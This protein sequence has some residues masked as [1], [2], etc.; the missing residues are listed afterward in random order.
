M[1]NWCYQKVTIA[2]PIDSRRN[3]AAAS[4][5]DVAAA[6]DQFENTQQYSFTK[7]VPLDA[8]AILKLPNEE[9]GMVFSSASDG[10]DGYEH[11][12]QLWGTKWGD[13][14]TWLVEENDDTSIFNFKSAWSPANNLLRELSV[15]YPDLLFINVYTEEFNHFAGFT[16]LK[17]GCWLEEYSIDI[18]QYLGSLA[19]SPDEDEHEAFQRAEEKMWIELNGAADKVFADQLERLSKS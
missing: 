13:V 12:L 6:A 5:S 8:R 7:L 14:D 16:M 19:P 15:K 17:A 11:A 4:K 18:D 9:H 1:P 2:G 10:F 3:L